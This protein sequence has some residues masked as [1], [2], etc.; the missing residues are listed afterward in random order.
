MKRTYSLFQEYIA[1][2]LLISFFLQS[3]GGF[4]NLPLSEKKKQKKRFQVHLQPVISITN[5][6]PL[7]DQQLT[8]QGGHAV[9]FYKYKD[10][11]LGSLQSLDEKDKVYNDLEVFIEE[12]TDL[13]NLR[14]LPKEVQAGRIHIQKN[15]T[16]KP[17]K[18]FLLQNAGIMGGGNTGNKEKKKDNSKS[19]N[20]KKSR[21][22]GNTSSEDESA[23]KIGE[24][25]EKGKEKEDRV[26]KVGELSDL[27]ILL[28]ESS[29][30]P[31]IFDSP[32]NMMGIS[33]G[34]YTLD[35]QIFK[36]QNV[37]GTGIDSFFNA[38]G[39]ERNRA[40]E[41]LE[42]L[43]RNDSVKP[44]Y[45]KMLGNELECAALQ[46]GQGF[47]TRHLSVDDAHALA[48]A[49]RSSDPSIGQ[50]TPPDEKDE[51]VAITFVNDFV[52]EAG[53]MSLVN[54]INLASEDKS[55]TYTLIDAIAA[56]NN[57]A[58]KVYQINSIQDTREHI[59]VKY[60]DA[61]EE[62]GVLEL[63]HEFS[64]KDIDPL[65]NSNKIIYLYYSSAKKSFQTF[66][67]VKLVKKKLW[68]FPIDL[69]SCCTCSSKGGYE[70]IE[71]P[72]GHKSIPPTYC[73]FTCC[74]P[75]KNKKFWDD[76]EFCLLDQPKRCSKFLVYPLRIGTFLA[77]AAA[78]VV[79]GAAA[80]VPD[81]GTKTSLAWAAFALTSTAAFCK[82]S[83]FFIQNELWLK[84]IIKEEEEKNKEKLGLIKQLNENTKH[85]TMFLESIGPETVVNSDLSL[86]SHR[87][88]IFSTTG[89]S[90]GTVNELDTDDRRIKRMEEGSLIK[91]NT[92]LIKHNTKLVK[93]NTK[94]TDKIDT[95]LDEEKIRDEEKKKY[96]L[97]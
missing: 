75:E 18:I 9:T 32:H 93:H 36:L 26:V 43:L 68:C 11:V 27:N 53:K 6:E 56:L 74:E 63:F 37:S 79:T 77:T 96:K 10:K 80:L 16:G 95:F 3:C 14:H 20:T 90:S 50:S 24:N 41:D 2:V 89:T 60:I 87:A 1:C 47:I 59:K 72:Q 44:I 30:E 52:K 31:I 57:V 76:T 51:K 48:K 25:V 19:K 91:H 64:P 54:N 94:L 34:E 4:N 42:A 15:S 85:N 40:I 66:I 83:E 12:G 58:I 38:T 28:I 84:A 29:T 45:K 62:E 61:P 73:C 35:N 13:R 21:Q 78:T 71:K 49:L 69:G 23:Y 67:P 22:V 86:Q 92:K 17:E 81:E 7:I 46:A 8:V 82:G 88:A 97:Y 39:V 5:I 65:N 70:L 55:S 33:K